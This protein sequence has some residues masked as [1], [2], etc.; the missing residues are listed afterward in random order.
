MIFVTH[1]SLGASTPFHPKTGKDLIY[2]MLDVR[3]WANRITIR[4]RQHPLKLTRQVLYLSFLF[5]THRR[6]SLLWP[7]NLRT[8]VSVVCREAL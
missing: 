6:H 8:G 4:Q 3:R 5:S 1:N 7:F 2:E